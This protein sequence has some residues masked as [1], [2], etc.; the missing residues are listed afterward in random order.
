MIPRWKIA[1]VTWLGIYPSLVLILTLVRPLIVSFPFLIETLVLT[2]VLVPLMT[3]VVMPLLTGW[4]SGWLHSP[5][6]IRVEN[7]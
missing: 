3:F 6:P 2:L 7:P 4:F 5:S 1:V